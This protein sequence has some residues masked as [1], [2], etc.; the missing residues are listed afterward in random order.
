MAQKKAFGYYRLSSIAQEVKQRSMHH[1]RGS[2]RVVGIQKFSS[3][4]GGEQMLLQIH[5]HWRLIRAVFYSRNPTHENPRHPLGLRILSLFN[6]ILSL[7]HVSSLHMGRERGMYVW[8]ECCYWCVGNGDLK[9]SEICT[10]LVKKNLLTCVF[11][12]LY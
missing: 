1:Y 4:V 8:M 5:Q 7:F 11:S 6:I 10:K 12:L 9:C 2:S 3:F